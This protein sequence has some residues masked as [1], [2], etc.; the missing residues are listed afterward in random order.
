MSTAYYVI[1]TMQLYISLYAPFQNV[2][3]LEMFRKK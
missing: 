1:K 3:Q 2:R